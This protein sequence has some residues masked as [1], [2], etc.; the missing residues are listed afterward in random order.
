MPA[1]R[2]TG[3][4]GGGRGREGGRERKGGREMTVRY[5]PV[6]VK[7]ERLR[8]CMQKSPSAETGNRCERGADTRNHDCTER[9]NYVL[10]APFCTLRSA[11][12]RVSMTTHGSFITHA[13]NSPSPDARGK[14][15]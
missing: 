10:H 2:N 6:A 9:Y 4:K 12:Q 14:Y 8:D 13:L 3:K 7:S 5:V 11:H 15:L 1:S